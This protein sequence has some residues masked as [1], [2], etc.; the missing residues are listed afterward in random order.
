MRPP[1]TGRR[2]IRSW[3]RSA[4]GWSGRGGAGRGGG[5]RAQLAAAMRAAS[6]VVSLI[7]GQDRPQMPLAE[8]QHPV[9]D[10]GPGGEHEP[11]RVSVRPWAAGRDLHGFD[12]GPG[13]DCVER[14]S[15]LPGSV[16]DQE[17]EVRGAV[18]QIRQEIADL[19]RGPGPVR[20]RRDTEGV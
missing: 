12:T 19:L 6:V 18:A 9:S 10:L 16:A 15:E 11:F 20:G 7:L 8:D 13:Q 3:V 5:G 17:P 14:L 4:T 1:R 2:W